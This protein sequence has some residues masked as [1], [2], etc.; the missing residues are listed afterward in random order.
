[1]ADGREHRL[2]Y[3][4]WPYPNLFAQATAQGRART[5]LAAALV[6]SPGWNDPFSPEP[7]PTD[8]VTRETNQSLSFQQGLDFGFFFA[9][10]AEL[11]ARAG[12]NPSWNTGVDYKKLLRQSINRD[13]VQALYTQANLSLEDDLD[14]LED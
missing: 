6:D 5:A 1:M 9:L 4:S 11:E 3:A 13:E 14:T 10:R 2:A 12:G 8:Y 7:S